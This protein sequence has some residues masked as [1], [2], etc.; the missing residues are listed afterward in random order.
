MSNKQTFELAFARL[1]E[2]LKKMSQGAVPLEESLSLYEEA[3][4]LIETC[5]KKLNEAEKKI[6]MLVK[7]DDQGQPVL[8]NFTL[9]NEA[10]LKSEATLREPN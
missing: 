10:P 9:K 1:E 5:N 6:E 4:K 2:I 3:D 7:I 8:E